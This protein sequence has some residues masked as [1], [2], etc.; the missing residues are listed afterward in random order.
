[1]ER[2]AFQGVTN[3]I[4]FNWHFYVIALACITGCI[5]F[6]QFLLILLIVLGTVVSLTVSWYVYDYSDLYTLDWMDFPAIHQLVNI[7]AGFDET[8]ILLAEKFPGAALTVFDF[9]DPAKHTEIS[10]ERARK[11]YG[12]YPGTINISTDDI[13]LVSADLICM[14]LAAHE[15]RNSAERM[16][17][18]SL[19][20]ERLND[21]GQMIVL[22]HLRD[23]PN[24]MAYNIGFFHFFSKKEWR[25]TFTGAGLTIH[26]E[27]KVTPFLSAFIL[28]KNGIT[29]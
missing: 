5:V 11:A 24:F 9:Y 3:I 17:F 18:F 15:I 25:R 1:M 27:I 13:P 14:M 19:L 10:I 8:S 26:K 2:V 6:H 28:Q 23:L 21:Q 22:E 20:K 29:S 12:P 7:N 4:R 16:M